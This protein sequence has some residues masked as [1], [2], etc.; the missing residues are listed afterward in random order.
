MDISEQE[1]HAYVDGELPPDAQAR[2]A[3]AIAADPALARR[4]DAE[5]ALRARLRAALD[6]VLEEPV[7]ARLR[8]LLD[9]PQPP[10]ERSATGMAPPRR[11]WRGRRAPVYA[12]AASLLV[13]GVAL[14]LRPE[15]LPVRWQDSRLMAAGPLA[16]ALDHALAADRASPVVVGLSF[17][18][19]DGRICRSFAHNDGLQG[20]ACRRDGGWE[21][22][23]L[24]TGG[25]LAGG[26]LRK[27]GSATAPEV[28]A[29]ID[30]RI[31][32]DTF[33]AAQERAARAAHWR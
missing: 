15:A 11:R 20:L 4:A 8:A 3:A 7:P 24:A 2:V 6:P 21:V 12:L 33:D 19:Q 27:A 14:W 1:L 23:L 18:G 16:D 28:Q 26:E 29:A 31:R 25:P 10:A 22:E 9:H 32:G 17:R 30:S 13:L 5:R